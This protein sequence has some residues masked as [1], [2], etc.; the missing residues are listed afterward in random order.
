MARLCSEKQQEPHVLEH[1]A[2][3][4]FEVKD[5]GQV[6]ADVRQLAGQGKVFSIDPNR[7][8]WATSET[9]VASGGKMRVEASPITMMKACNLSAQR[10]ISVVLTTLLRR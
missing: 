6:G 3:A 5:Y 1:A 7:N 2:A 8:N 9:I 10:R 4:G